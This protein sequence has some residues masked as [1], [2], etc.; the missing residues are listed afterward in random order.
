MASHPPGWARTRLEPSGSDYFL[1]RIYPRPVA[2]PSW[3]KDLSRGF[4]RSRGGR[5]GWFIQLHHD[6]L[7]LVSAELPPR[8]EDPPEAGPQKRAVTLRT[9]PAPENT[10][11][12]LTEAMAVYTA[13]LEGTW[14]WP[15]PE[16]SLEADDARRLRPEEL[17]KLVLKLEKRLLGE[18]VGISTW[19]RTYVPF[20]QKLQQQAS[21]R[22]WLI[23]HDLIEAT[24]RNWAPNSRSRQ[25]A[26][27]RYRQLWKEAGWPWPESLTT[28]RGNGKAAA[29]A[30]GVRAFSDPEIAELRARIQASH[31]LG[32]DDLVAWDC[33]VVFGLRPAELKGLTLLSEQGHPIAVVSHAKRNS[34]G[35]TGPRRVPAVPPAGWPVHCHDLV[36]RFRAHGL[37]AC[38]IQHRSPG[39]VLSQQLKRLRDRKLVEHEIASELTSYGLRHAFALRLGLDLGL[40]V[41]ESAALMG[42][43]PTVHLQTYG[44]RLE[45][46]RLEARVRELI[47]RPAC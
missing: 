39:E 32:E 37:P 42:H 8:P 21:R 10:T 25:M 7:R 27:N 9:P 23:D 47:N 14:S 24:L 33:L 5:G 34:K 41:R 16:D 19:Q 30:E 1:P 20:F 2:S 40:H 45:M 17:A 35:S 36:E 22:Q 38:V 3:L 4:K 31:R 43:S 12:A 6:R 15:D 46:P 13:V 44:R 28:L 11:D 29:A 26:F 18:T